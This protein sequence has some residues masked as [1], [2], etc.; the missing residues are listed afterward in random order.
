MRGGSYAFPGSS[1]DSPVDPAAGKAKCLLVRPEYYVHYVK[2]STPLKQIDHNKLNYKDLVF[3]WLSVFQHLLSKV[4]RVMWAT[5]ISY[6]NRP[7]KVTL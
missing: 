5:V 1:T 3:G 7:W 6:K 4:S 2:N